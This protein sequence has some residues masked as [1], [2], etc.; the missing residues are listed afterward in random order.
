MPNTSK[1]N[2]NLEYKLIDHIT[3]VRYEDLPPETVDYCKLLIMDALGV[4]TPG[5]SFRSS[6]ISRSNDINWS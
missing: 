2:L 5:R 4:T 1:S 6:G 3:K